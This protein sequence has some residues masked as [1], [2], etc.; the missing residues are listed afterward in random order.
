M[1]TLLLFTQ[2]P[3]NKTMALIF[4]ELTGGQIHSGHLDGWHI[5]L[6]L[7]SITQV[8]LCSRQIIQ[9]LKAG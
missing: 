9:T 3:E 2:K 8:L 1:Q 6:G 7:I 5:Y 4:L